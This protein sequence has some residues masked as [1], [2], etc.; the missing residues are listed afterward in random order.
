[1]M[2]SANVDLSAR[3][4]R[5]ILAQSARRNDP[6]DPDWE[7]GAAGGFAFNPNYGFGAVDADRA[8]ELAR[9]WDTV[10]T[11][12][13][14]MSCTTS[15]Q[16]TGSNSA[17]LAIPDAQADGLRQV[18]RIEP[19]CPI[20]RIEFVELRLAIDH[21]Y[22]G[23][24]D[25]DLAS[26]S[27]TRSL[28]ARARD[29]GTQ[30]SGRTEDCGQYNDAWPITTVRHL[31]EPATGDWHLVISDRVAGKIGNLKHWTLKVWGR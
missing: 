5:L 26:P 13:G 19:S 24:L 14:L 25:I 17:P 16:T 20:R 7:E 1:L 11:E 28:L 22:S 31:N 18:M 10:G 3:D 23:D 27:G 8:V 4:V 9:T 21:Q 6:L 30:G 29:C 12:S 15:R 2:L